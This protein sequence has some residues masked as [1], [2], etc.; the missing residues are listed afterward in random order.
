MS[1]TGFWDFHFLRPHQQEMDIFE[2]VLKYI[3]FLSSFLHEHRF[4]SLHTVMQ[5]SRKHSTTVGGNR[6]ISVKHV[7]NNIM[8]SVEM[9]TDTNMAVGVR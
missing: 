2:N 3:S 6:N 4:V 5:S 9:Q 1:L 7:E 8:S